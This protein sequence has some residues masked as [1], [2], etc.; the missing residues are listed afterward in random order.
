MSKWKKYK[1]NPLYNLRPYIL[2]EDTSGWN[3]EEHVIPEEGGM[4]ELGSDGVQS[5]LTKTFY[6][7][8]YELAVTE[9]KAP[10]F[11]LFKLGSANINKK[12]Q[13]K[14]AGSKIELNKKTSINNAL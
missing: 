7:S 1:K 4:V 14:S 3:I 6:E 9:T 10:G 8:N 13:G 12:I 11:S 2:G 5:Y